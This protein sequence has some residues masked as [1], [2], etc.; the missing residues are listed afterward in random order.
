MQI[1]SSQLSD[2]KAGAKEKGK[3]NLLVLP[4]KFNYLFYI[5]T[6]QAKA[7]AFHLRFLTRKTCLEI[8]DLS[9]N[10]C[11]KQYIFSFCRNQR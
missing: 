4:L 7:T 3:A 9:A 1:K 6:S 11:L 2:L 5:D 10:I 8:T